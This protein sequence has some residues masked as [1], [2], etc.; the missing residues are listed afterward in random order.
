MKWILTVATLAMLLG[1]GEARAQGRVKAATEAAEFLIGRFGAKAGRT[2]PELAGQIERVAARYGD[3]AVRAIRNGGPGAAGLVEA[4]GPDGAKALRVLAAH[5]EHGATRVLSRPAAMKQFLQHGDDAAV[6]LVR[7]PG[8]AE[9][10]VEKGGLQAAKALA[11]VDPRNGR[12]L[13]MML[14]GELAQVGRHPE[15]LGVVAAHGDRA[16]NFVW[17][18]KG[19][20]ASGAA[21]AA[22]LANPEPFLNGTR[23]IA[24]VAGEAVVK[25]VVGGVVSVVSY[26][27]YGLGAVLVALTVL[28]FKYGPPKLETLASLFS[29]FK[30]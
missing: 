7:H 12:R 5:G 2:V 4:A 28:L 29:Q 15:L 13:A 11:A 19:T 6:A 21:L 22:F 25:P 3:D 14:D 16:L 27:L 20:F 23:D 8:I 10:L 26:A 9:P 17:Q 30:K 24:S 18:H 1:A